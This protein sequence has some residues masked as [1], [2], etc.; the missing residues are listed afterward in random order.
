M[1]RVAQRTLGRDQ[2]R[3]LMGGPGWPKSCPGLPLLHPTF[4]TSLKLHPRDGP[5]KLD[6]TGPLSVATCPISAIAGDDS[7]FTLA[8]PRRRSPM[9]SGGTADTSAAGV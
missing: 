5:I 9:S 8:R 7:R 2:R 3:D 1:P 4:H 6:S